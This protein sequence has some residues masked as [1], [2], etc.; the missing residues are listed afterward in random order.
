MRDLSALGAQSFDVV[1]DA[2]AINFVPDAGVVFDQVRRVIR[3]G[4]LYRVY[5][6]N[7]FSWGF[8]ESD[9]NGQGYNLSKHYRSGAGESNSP[10]YWDF[11][12]LDGV[13][14]KLE[15]PRDFNHALSAVFNGLI[16]RG[17]SLQG[18]WEVEALDLNAAPGSWE[19]MQLVM[20]QWLIVWARG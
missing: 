3:P 19:H 2:Y 17:F 18:L 10:E 14:Q 6:A 7:P 15:A 13:K 1:Y 11:T 12:D 9:W 5:F 16:G 4:G 8:D 20:P